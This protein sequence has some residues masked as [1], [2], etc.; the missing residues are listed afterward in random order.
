MDNDG[1][2]EH[3]QKKDGP[4]GQRRILGVFTKKR[5]GRMDND[6]YLEH[7]LKKKDGPYGQQRILGVFTKKGTGRMDNDGYLEHS[8]LIQTTIFQ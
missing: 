6:G 3:S 8:Q 7:S 1:Y 2:L 5:T 4:Y